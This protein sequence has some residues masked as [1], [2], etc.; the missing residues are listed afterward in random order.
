MNARRK[1]I[2]ALKEAG[3]HFERPGGKHDIYANDSVGAMIPV[4]HHFTDEDLK[5]VLREIEKYGKGK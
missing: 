3:Y 2:E 1:A 5:V 4:R